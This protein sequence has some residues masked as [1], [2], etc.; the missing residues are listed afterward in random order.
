MMLKNLEYLKEVFWD[1]CYFYSSFNDL[2]EM[3]KY[4]TRVPAT[5][6]KYILQNKRRITK[7]R[8]QI[9]VERNI[10]DKVV[11]RLPLEI[12]FLPTEASAPI[13]KI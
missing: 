10:S 12:C 3:T 9:S 7:M 11:D 8:K 13:F 6:L 2:K 1:L 4:Y 5:N